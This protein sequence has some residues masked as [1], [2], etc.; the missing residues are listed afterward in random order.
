MYFST[1][2]NVLSNKKKTGILTVSACFLSLVSV[3]I[4]N[5]ISFD[6]SSWG[7]G[8]ILC[9]ISGL[10][11]GF[12]IAGTGVFAKKLYA[13]MYLATQSLVGM[14]V[15]LIF[16]L[17]LNSIVV[18]NQLGVKVPVEKIVFS[19]K[20]EYIIFTIFYV[21]I[22]NTLCWIIRTNSMK[23]ID[24]TV[25]SIIMP[26]SA[27]ITGILSVLAGND[28]LNFN[29]VAGGILGVVAVIMSSFDDIKSKT[30]L[31]KQH[32]LE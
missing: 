26:F 22:C 29:L 10:L 6:G 7:I 20:I 24:P 31:R 32:H 4:L 12:N 2:F 3:F 30:P 21:I 25:V 16:A 5:G 8:E 13:P 23:H 19:F 27:V 17:A 28:A 11:Y 9:A 18:T 1:C 15:S 14:V